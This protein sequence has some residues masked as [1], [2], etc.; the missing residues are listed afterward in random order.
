MFRYLL[1]AFVQ[2]FRKHIVL[3]RLLLCL[4]IGIGLSE[5]VHAAPSTIT[6]TYGHHLFSVQIS[7]YPQWKQTE[8]Q[9]SFRGI[10]AI[11]PA[12]MLTCGTGSAIK[13]GWSYREVQQWD[14]HAIEKTINEKIAS[15]LNRNTNAVTI[16]RSATGA[17]LFEGKGLPGRR[18]LSNLAAKLTIQALD[19]GVPTIVLPVMEEKPLVTIDSVLRTE[20]IKE[21]VMVGESVF[22]GSPKN[23]RHNIAVGISKFNGHIIPKNS[24][25]S[26]N[27]TLGPVNEKTGY[28][29]ELVIEGNTTIPDYGGGLCQVS[30]TAYR[31]PWEY[32]LPIIQRKNHSYAVSYYGPQGTDATIYPP[33]V[34]MKFMNNTPGSLLIQSFLDDNDHAYFVYYGTDDGRT[35]EVFGPYISDRKKAPK[36][37][38]I[39]FTKELP[40]SEKRKAGESHDGLTALWYRFSKTTNTGA[41]IERFFSL[42]E[43]R[44]VTWQIGIGATGSSIHNESDASVTPSWLPSNSTSNR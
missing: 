29:K 32:G 4:G 3:W 31:G 34:D 23:R 30:S 43:A 22:T 36:E 21:V 5:K 35:S 7:A 2:D 13:K 37:E 1:S 42:Y 39:L 24:I 14:I 18:V 17:I 10:R 28:K 33:A 40:A 9:W 41:T 11:P 20:G 15:V 26:F 6:Y 38:L 19:E 12:A 27:E 16:H 8:K 25:F 44:P